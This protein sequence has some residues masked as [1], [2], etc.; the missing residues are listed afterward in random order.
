MASKVIAVIQARMG[1]LRLPGKSL[2]EIEGKPLLEHIIDRIRYSKTIDEIIIATTT[3]HEDKA[4]INLAKKLQLKVYAGKIIDVLD[5][6]YQA[7]NLYGGEVI[8]RITADDPF[9]DPKIIDY[10]VNYY[11]LHP[12]LDYVSNTIDPTYPIG[13]DVEVFSFKALKKA[14]REAKTKIARE[15]VTPYIWSNSGLFKIA[16]IKH[17]IDL[18]NLRWTIDTKE[19]L[20]MAREVYKKLYDKDKIFY[21]KDILRLLKKDTYI[22]NLNSNI[23]QIVI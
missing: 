10:I 5:R 19:D 8:V 18:T 7:I 4:I 6:F 15:H 23:K 2:M 16:N 12:E 9:K 17:H 11:L 14:W 1:S 3:E 21:M 20:E 13:I 22:S